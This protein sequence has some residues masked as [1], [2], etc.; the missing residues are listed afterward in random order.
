MYNDRFSAVELIHEMYPYSNENRNFWLNM[1]AK[2]TKALEPLKNMIEQK[3]SDIIFIVESHDEYI[4]DN[5][6]DY[7]DE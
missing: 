3:G 2:A 5:T 6:E 1:P 4:E 7:D